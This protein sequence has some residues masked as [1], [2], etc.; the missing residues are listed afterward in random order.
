M[1]TVQ[2]FR[3]RVSSLARTRAMIVNCRM[4]GVNVVTYLVSNYDALSGS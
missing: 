1:K 3:T 2:H 4:H